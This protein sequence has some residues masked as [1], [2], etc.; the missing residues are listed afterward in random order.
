[1]GILLYVGYLAIFFATWTINGVDYNRIGESAE[2]TKLWYAFPTLF[3]CAFLV[4]AISV[5]G[6]WRMVL[7]DKSKSGPPWI[8]ILPATMSAIILN[9]FLCVHS[10]QLSAELLLWS[11]LGAVGVGFGE[12]M[13]TRG[14]LVV[15][16]RSRFGESRV[17]LISTLLFSALHV[18]NVI[19]GLSMWAMPVQVLLTFIMGSGLYVIRRMSG[20][21][22]L[23][24]F[25]HGLWDS[26]VFLNIATG[27]QP[28]IAQF[29]VYPLAIVCTMVV[30]R[31]SRNSRS[32]Q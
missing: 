1:M 14:S 16:L 23:P 11:S 8:W 31:N 21:L 7:F 24:M 9:N 27:T 19:F 5:L 6:W 18:P 20:T 3:G 12:E 22:V 15:G 4:V 30:V 13:I 2:S 32:P 17:W 25:L 29:A 10:D 28:S 26:S